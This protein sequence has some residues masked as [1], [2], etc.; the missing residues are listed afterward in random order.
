MAWQPTEDDLRKGAPH[1]SYEIKTLRA[2]W[3]HHLSNPF[4]YTAWF[5]HT[6]NLMDF[7][8]GKGRDKDLFARHYIDG[9][10]W[11]DALQRL[12]RP[13]RYSEYWEAVSRQAAHLTFHRVELET[14]GLV[15]D[16]QITRHLLGLALQFIQMLPPPRA[17]W[18]GDLLL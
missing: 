9:T 3:E 4:A 11:D 12:T 8:D 2:A 10:A 14:K 17:A 16:E 7:F 5:T 6:R 13:A 15:P 18:F 1:A